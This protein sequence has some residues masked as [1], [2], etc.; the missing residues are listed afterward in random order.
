MEKFIEVYDNIL[1]P[2]LVDLIESFT[3]LNS[4]IP[5]SYIQN[6]TYPSNHP[7]YKFK[8]GI[9]HSLKDSITNTPPSNYLNFYLN[10]LYGLCFYK[11]IIINQVLHGR[12]F[13]D[14][15]TPNPQLDGPPHI[16]L[17]SP[18]WVC[19]YYINDSDG[20]TVFFK[21]DMKTE[22]K[23]VPPKKGRIAFFDGSIY[24]AGTPSETNSRAV[25]NFNFTP[26]L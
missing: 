1:D 12:L 18:H 10:I 5:F 8:P 19:L 21:D 26:Y 14:F 11:K 24:H 15:P 16:D 22:I 25:V 13:V 4:Q 3:L 17:N 6:L 7:Q 23:R 9:T 2:K 20:D